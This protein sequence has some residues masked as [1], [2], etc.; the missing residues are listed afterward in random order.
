M[1]LRLPRPAVILAAV[2]LA[3]AGA[4]CS[5]GDGDEGPNASSSSPT[6]RG[7]AVELRLAGSELRFDVE[8]LAAPADLG[9]T[10]VFD[11]RDRGIP[12]NIA[13]YRSGPPAKEEVAKTDV[14]PG[15]T[16]QR[17]SVPALAPGRYFYQ[18]DVHPTT[19]TG[20]LMV[21]SRR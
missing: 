11:N 5:S 2:A 8:T 16:T 18:C 12:H 4:G 3:L 15:P 20:T 21:T 6:A 9:F 10:I 7:E 17:L 13:V 1:P 14:E 19:M